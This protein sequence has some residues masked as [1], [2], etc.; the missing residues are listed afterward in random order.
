MQILAAKGLLR[1]PRSGGRPVTSGEASNVLSAMTKKLAVSLTLLLAVSIAALAAD[2]SGRWTAQVPG[3]GGEARETTFTF[4]VEGDKLT[5]TMSVQGQQA[6]IADG[7]IAG[8]TLSFTVTV[9]RGG[10]QIKQNYTGKVVGA[11]IQFKREGGQGQ[12]REFIAK[13]ATT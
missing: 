7:K 6:P 2:V 5:G 13:R 11:E 9:E 8:D 4:K 10:N 3:R 12:P 1:A